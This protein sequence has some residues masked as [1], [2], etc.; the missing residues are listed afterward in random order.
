V[1]TYSE[2]TCFLSRGLLQHQCQ[3]CGVKGRAVSGV[4]AVQTLASV[5][6]P[7]LNLCSCVLTFIVF[8]FSIVFIPVSCQAK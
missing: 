5:L 7:Q 6:L 4:I 2:L 8:T 3:I 1:G